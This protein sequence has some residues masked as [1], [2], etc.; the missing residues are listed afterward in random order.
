MGNFRARSSF[1]LGDS[2]RINFGFNFA[3]IFPHIV[4][5]NYVKG[6][7]GY[8][9]LGGDGHEGDWSPCFLRQFHDWECA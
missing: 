8:G 9:C 6:C 2:K 5:H 1:K 7:L 4:F 3:C